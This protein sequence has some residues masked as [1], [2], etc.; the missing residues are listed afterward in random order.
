MVLVSEA[1]QNPREEAVR[2]RE[3]T[4]EPDRVVSWLVPSESSVRAPRCERPVRTSPSS[5]PALHR[6]VR[7]PLDQHPALTSAASGTNRHRDGPKVHKT[8]PVVPPPLA[9]SSTR[10]QPACYLCHRSYRSVSAQ[11]GS[12]LPPQEQEHVMNE[13]LVEGELSA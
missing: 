1:A 3:M 4:A 9:C 11:P 5:L 6:S 8:W 7:Y 10:E 13:L 12:P 2:R